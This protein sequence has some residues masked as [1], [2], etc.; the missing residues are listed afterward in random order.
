MA[1]A[2]LASAPRLVQAA[3]GQR[4]LAY[5]GTYSSPVDGGGNGK[6]IYL[7]EMNPATG[8]L[9]LIELAAEAHNAGWLS[10][11]PSG[12]FLYAA[13]EV[14][15]FEGKSGA[16]SAYA[17]DRKTGKLHLLNMVSSQGAGP[18]HLSVDAV[19]QVCVC[20]KLCRR[21]GSR[22]AHTA[23][24]SA[25]RTHLRSPGHWLGW[26]Q[27]SIERASGQLCVQ[28]ARQAACPHDP[29]R[30]EQSLRRA[31]RPG[32][33]P[34]LCFRLSMLARASCRR[35][36]VL[37]FPCPR[38]RAAPLYL[39]SQWALVLLAAGRSIHGDVFSF[40][41]GDW[42]SESSADHFD[43]ASRIQGDQFH[44]GDS[45]LAGRPISLCI[46]SASRHSRHLLR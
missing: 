38:G 2:A 4:T 35:L 36:P 6:G 45:A 29:C 8:E 30:P 10:F 46:Q 41:S 42:I 28:R 44:C 33:G 12:R 40:R 23:D 25:G 21:H 43:A 15:D 18:A 26:T 13:N 20:C 9:T 1:V 16:V 14:T 7:F 11:D 27:D 5:V 31:N 3:S 24:G 17:V 37:P 19:G 34:D 39:S 22:A 32:A